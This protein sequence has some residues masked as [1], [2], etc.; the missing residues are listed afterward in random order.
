MFPDILRHQ[1]CYF[2]KRIPWRNCFISPK[3]SMAPATRNTEDLLQHVHFAA[4]PEKEIPA[5]SGYISQ[6]NQKEALHVPPVPKCRRQSQIFILSSAKSISQAKAKKIWQLQRP[7]T[8]PFSTTIVRCRLHHR[9]QAFQSDAMA[10]LREEG[11]SDISSDDDMEANS[12]DDTR[13]FEE[14]VDEI[15]SDYQPALTDDEDED[16]EDED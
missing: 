14:F 13:E 11:G 12:G 2:R 10:T 8:M 6:R 4:F 1:I 16:C 3:D 9:I 7:C 5:N 15:M